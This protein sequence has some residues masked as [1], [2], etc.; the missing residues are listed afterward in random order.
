MKRSITRP[1]LWTKTLKSTIFIL[2]LSLPAAGL[3]AQWQGYTPQLPDTFGTFDLRIAHGNNQV[4]WAAIAK[5]KVTP[6]TYEY[7]I[8]DSAYY[9][10]TSDGGNTWTGGAVDM[11]PEPYVNNFSPVSNDIAWTSGVDLN[12]VSY[13]LKTTDGGNTWTRQLEDGF[14]GPAGYVDFVHFWDAQNGVAVGDPDISD[15][16][17]IPF[18]EIYTTSDGGSNWSRV[19]SSPGLQPYP[20]E[21]GAAG[22]YQVKG[23]YVWF[24]TIDLATFLSKRLYRSK[25]RGYHWEELTT[26][27]DKLGLFSFSDTL[28]GITTIRASATLG[29]FFYTENG[30][31][32]WT[33]LPSFSTTAEEYMTS[34]VLIPQSNYILRVMSFDNI[35]GPFKTLLSKDLGQSWIELGTTENAGDMKFA[36][37][38]VG[39]AG[40]WQPVDHRNKMYKYAG[41]PLTGLLSGQELVADISV[42]PNPTSDVLTVQVTTQEPSPFSLLL[43]DTQG[44]LID[45]ITL[46]KTTAVNATFP[47]RHLPAGVYSITVCSDKGSLTKNV[48]KQ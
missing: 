40:E 13:V 16:D 3:L 4:A 11:G 9:V 7:V 28:H 27:A 21:Y 37:P 26:S 1:C 43:H 30:G 25:D 46:E 33:E 31:D 32:T 17:T 45:Q 6:T 34:M 47:M 42:S 35:A 36:S 20:N 41:S 22:F 23:D 38:T 39:Y 10:K 48:V 44:R 8:K 5:Y 12:F 19:P 2:A 24:G 29:K 18:Y 15:S 14:S